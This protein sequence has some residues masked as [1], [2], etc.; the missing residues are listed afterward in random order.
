MEIMQITTRFWKWKRW[1][2]GLSGLGLLSLLILLGG[3]PRLGRGSPIPGLSAALTSTGTLVLTVTNGVASEYYTIYTEP[4]LQG[5]FP[6]S[7]SITGSVGVTNFVIPISPALSGFY[8]AEAGFD[9]DGDGIPSWE[10]ANPDGPTIGVLTISI[11]SPTN[12]ASIH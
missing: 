10:D 6:W 5:P 11:A 3:L 12:G 7:G 1:L 8:K 2:G 9:R 4:M